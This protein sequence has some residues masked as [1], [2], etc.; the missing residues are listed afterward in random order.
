[1]IFSVV[2]LRGYHVLFLAVSLLSFF[3]PAIADGHGQV[4]MGSTLYKPFCANACRHVLAKSKLI[5]DPRL[6]SSSSTSTS[7]GDTHAHS[8]RHEHSE[9]L[10]TMD[11]LLHDAAFLRT[12]SLC[13]EQFCAKRD[14]VPNWVIEE[15]WEGHVGTSESVGDWSEEMRPGMA[16]AEALIYAKADVQ[17]AGGTVPSAVPGEPLN[18]TSTVRE[19]DWTGEY[20]TLVWFEKIQSEM[21]WN[22]VAIALSM[23]FIPVFLSLFRFLPGRPLWYSR[24]VAVLERPLIGHR[25]R[26][27][28]A[29]NLGFMPTRGQSLYILYLIATQIFLCIFPLTFGPTAGNYIGP[30]KHI[31]ILV[32]IGDRSGLLAMANF[33]ALFLFSGRNNV[34]LWVTGWS[35][36]TF[37]LLHRWIAYCTIAQ[38]CVH[39]AVLLAEYWPTHTT[40]QTMPYWIWGTVGTLLF[41]LMWPLSILPVRQRMY[42]FFLLTHQLF[43][44]LVLIASFLHVYLLFGYDW[45]Y[46]YW[47]YVAGILWFIDRAVRVLRVVGN[48]VKR[49]VVTPVTGSGSGELEYVRVDVE[50]IVAEGHVYLYFPTLSWKFWENHPF[51]VISSF[52]GSVPPGTTAVTSPDDKVDPEK[53]SVGSGSDASLAAVR[54]RATLLLRLQAGSTQSLAQRLLSSTAQNISLPVFVES[55]YHSNPNAQRDLAHCSSLLVFAGGVGITAVLPLLKTFGG[56]KAKMFWGVR[57]ESL[58]QALEPEFLHDLRERRGTEVSVRIGDRW[59][60]K[61]LVKAE[62]DGTLEAGDLGIVVCGP[63]GMADDV[64]SAVGEYGATA[65]R[66]VVFV[67]EA[68][69]W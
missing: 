28:V 42:E 34:L 64:R 29:F 48:G 15:Y 4:G 25:H 32:I 36:G 9:E 43:A 27:P 41:V 16:Y 49:A 12:L 5:C 2:R 23:V 35:H 7:S 50:G 22:S 45:G 1:M 46:E 68:F 47:V 44:A 17:A 69:A 65:K 40:D 58:A 62:L 30:T 67:D 31:Q 54:P 66:G 51:S 20:V 11:C 8:K 61:G 6:P 18:V 55:A 24:L 37:L 39:S 3:A 10:N 56:S 53:T 19:E 60:V 59:D 33:V 38:V 13:L 52:S 26:T 63:A 57:D 21:T 14:R